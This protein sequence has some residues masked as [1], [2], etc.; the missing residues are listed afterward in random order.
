[1]LD[2]IVTAPARETR[3]QAILLG[4]FAVAL[5]LRLAHLLEIQANDPFFSLPEVDGQEYHAQAL[6]ISQ[7]DWAGEGVLILGPL[8]PGFMALVYA[9]FGPDFFVLKLLQAV[10]GAVDCLLVFWLARLHFD[11]ATALVAA[12]ATAVYRMLVFY[13]GTV[14]Y[15]NLLV[16]LVLLCAIQVTRAIREPTPL[17][18]GLAGVVVSAAAL[19]R[20]DLLLFAA[21]VFG[22]IFWALRERA[23]LGHRAAFAAAFAAGTALLI[24]PFSARNWVVADDFVL[25]N[26]TA[27]M[28]LYMGN[29]GRANGAWVPPDFGKLRVDSPRA[30]QHA[31]RVMAE[32]AE[33]RELKPSEVSAF[34]RARAVEAIAKNPGRWLRLEVRKLLLFWNAREVWNNQSIDVIRDFSWVLRVPLLP[35]AAIAPLALLGLGLARSRFS[36]L[37]AMYAMVAVFL[38]TG[39]LLFVLARYRVGV[40]PILLIFAAYAVT[41]LVRR[42]RERRFAILGLA[43]G[44]LAVL[45]V[46]VHQDM[47][48]ENLYMAYFN[49]GN[50]YRQLE[51][52]EEAIA[53]YEKS[54]ELD[55]NYIGSHNNLALAYE[56]AGR[57]EEATERWREVFRRAQ[58][59]GDAPR[60]DR[61]ARHLRDLLGLPPD[62]KPGDPVPAAQ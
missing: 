48:E 39:L 34:W 15:E 19:A 45:A 43:A 14:M 25:L 23:S 6:A 11:S 49:L 17:R 5:L 9:L 26:S 20:Q 47:G 3:E 38:A 18:F 29:S 56:G 22:W 8:Y 30:M 12:A 41:T 37:F 32:R 54:L 46:F 21:L 1:M 51:R 53:A 58:R 62:W 24:L 59:A 44:W 27:G 16:P 28:N 35:F 55:P 33:G 50:K 57:N 60:V 31:F 13:G 36:E 42:V 52:Y 61:A 2:R 7:G 40:V 10:L 4:I